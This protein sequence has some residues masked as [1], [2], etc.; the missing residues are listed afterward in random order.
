MPRYTIT[1]SVG[2]RVER[3]SRFEDL[4]KHRPSSGREPGRDYATI[5]GRL[6][7]VRLQNGRTFVKKDFILSQDMPGPVYIPAPAS[8][9]VHHLNDS[10]NAIRLYDRP[11]GTPG[12]LMLAQSLHMTRGTS[13]PPGT[14][15]E[16]GA[17]LG[18]MGDTGRADVFEYI[19]RFHNPRMR[20]RLARQ[21]Q[22]SQPFH[23]RP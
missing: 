1:E 16:Y 8:G 7:E 14:F 22:N 20:R 18:Q 19:E 9:Y 6:E 3:V 4:E 2:R 23:N 10:T 12:A 11:F 21:D 15:I 17:P 13:P 5:E